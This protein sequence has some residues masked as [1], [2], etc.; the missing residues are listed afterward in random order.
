MAERGVQTFPGVVEIGRYSDEAG[1]EFSL[2]IDR[3]SREAPIGFESELGGGLLH[4]FKPSKPPH[5]RLRDQ[6]AGQRGTGSR[7]AWRD[8][9]DWN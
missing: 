9:S 8:G 6:W 5:P 7:R 2:V 4:S 1:H 3:R